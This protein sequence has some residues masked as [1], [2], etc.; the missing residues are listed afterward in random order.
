VLLAFYSF[1][2]LVDWPPV[3]KKKRKKELELKSV[4]ATG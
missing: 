4:H 2:A 3:S 1:L